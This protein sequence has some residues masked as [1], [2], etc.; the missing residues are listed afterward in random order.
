MRRLILTMAALTAFFVTTQTSSA[1]L[2]TFGDDFEDRD[3]AD[4]Q[5]GQGW[6]FF[7]NV[8]DSGTYL[9]GYPG[10]APNGPQISALAVGEGG[11]GQGDQQLSVYS[12]YE[13]CAGGGPGGGET[14][15]RSP[16]GLVETNVFQEQ[17]IDASDV[18]SSWTFTWDAK[19]GNIE[20]ESE[21]LAFLKVLDPQ[22]GFSATALVTA[23]MTTLSDS[24]AT[25]GLD[26]SIGDWE[27]QILQFGFLTNAAN[28]EGSNNFYDNVSF[29]ATVPVPGALLLMASGLF[30]LS[31]GRVKTRLRKF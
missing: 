23:D 17:V 28:F 27:G 10:A 11:V 24:W 1:S 19:R 20:G 12:D 13:C 25:Y 26:L 4:S 9:F 14:G 29:G 18:G 21:A 7:I 8:F 22:N 5:I 15:H 30:G 16:T 31:L 2:F 3:P 6:R